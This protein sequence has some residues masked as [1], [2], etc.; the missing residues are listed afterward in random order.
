MANERYNK[1]LEEAAKR[2]QERPI[3]AAP[4][5]NPK[6]KQ[7]AGDVSKALKKAI[8]PRWEMDDKKVQKKAKGG[9]VRGAGCATKGYGKGKMK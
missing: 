8:G 6:I 7:V 5:D 1:A 4:R 9:R 3:A 2:D